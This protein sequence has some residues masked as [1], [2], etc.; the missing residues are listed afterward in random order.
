MLVCAI[1]TANKQIHLETEN[2][3]VTKIGPQRE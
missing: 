3:M 2:Y 1:N